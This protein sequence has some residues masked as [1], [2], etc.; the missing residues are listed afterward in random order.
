MKPP[1]RLFQRQDG[2]AI[3]EAVT[4][5]LLS[6]G[7][8]IG[9]MGLF[10]R[11]IV[12]FTARYHLNSLLL[13]LASLTPPQL[14]EIQFQKKVQSLFIFKESSHLRVKNLLNEIQVSFQVEPRGTPSLL[15]ER[16]LLLPLKRNL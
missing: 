8:F 13:C 7:L 6:L 4:S 11:C 5:S 14:C 15:L 2:Q 10:Y 9:L 3:I 16:K 12:Y 1:I